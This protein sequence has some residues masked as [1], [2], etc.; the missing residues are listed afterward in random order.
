MRRNLRNSLRRFLKTNEQHPT[1]RPSRPK[2]PRNHREGTTQLRE[3]CAHRRGVL[4]AITHAVVGK[5]GGDKRSEE[6]Q[7][8]TDNI[9]NDKLR[10]ESHGTSNTYA[11]RKLRKDREGTPQLRAACAKE[12]DRARAMGGAGARSLSETNALSTC[13]RRR[14]E[15]RE[16]AAQEPRSELRCAR[17]RREADERNSWQKSVSEFCA[18]VQ[19]RW[20]HNEREDHLHQLE[21][22]VTLATSYPRNALAQEFR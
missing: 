20:G 3:A 18:P 15:A 16:A 8:N 11:L 2:G 17:S 7:T 4:S 21:E 9:S 14:G 22:E 6:Y 19:Q 1:R 13:R 12:K 5:P 10:N